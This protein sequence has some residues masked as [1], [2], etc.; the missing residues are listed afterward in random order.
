VPTYGFSSAFTV[1]FW[2]K[3]I[4]SVKVPLLNLAARTVYDAFSELRWKCVWLEKTSTIYGSAEQPHETK[5]G[6]FFRTKVDP[7][8]TPSD[9]T[10]MRLLPDSITWEF[11]EKNGFEVYAR[12][13]SYIRKRSFFNKPEQER[14]SSIVQRL[15]EQVVQVA[16]K[17]AVRLSI[18]RVQ[19]HN[20]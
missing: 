19:G 13:E 17:R 7:F 2:Y 12:V 9:F 5:I 18:S 1:T 16:K 15:L 6:A 8:L 11:K 10:T 3:D 4:P 20:P 14:L